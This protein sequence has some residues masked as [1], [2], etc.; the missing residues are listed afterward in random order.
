MLR[1]ILKPFGR[2]K[3]DELHD[4]PAGVWRKMEQDARAAD[5]KKCPGQGPAFVLDDFAEVVPW[6]V[7]KQASLRGPHRDK[8]RLGTE[9]RKAAA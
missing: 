3:A 1:R 2:F 5:P 7:S 9:G 4:F 6:D 8:V